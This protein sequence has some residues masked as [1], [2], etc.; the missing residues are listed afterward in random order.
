MPSDR[1]CYVR[2]TLLVAM[3]TAT[4]AYADCSE[5]PGLIWT[6]NKDF[7]SLRFAFGRHDHEAIC[8]AAADA[9]KSEGALYAFLRANPKCPSSERRANELQVLKNPV[10]NLNDF[11]GAHPPSVDDSAN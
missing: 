10:F 8:K 7:L 1:M 3:L 2:I 9:Y 11:C 5:L 4:N 6:T